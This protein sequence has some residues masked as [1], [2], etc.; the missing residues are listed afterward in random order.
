M[1]ED[2]DDFIMMEGARMGVMQ[3]FY[4]RMCQDMYVRY[5]ELESTFNALDTAAITA[6]S[7]H[8]D[9]YEADLR[10]TR[11]RDQLAAEAIKLIVIACMCLEAAIYDYAAW[12]LPPSVVDDQVERLDLY[13]KWRQ[14][15]G[16]VAQRE[17][18]A[19]GAAMG[20][21]KR[22]IGLRNRLVHS[23]SQ[24]MP[25]AE[26]LPA[27]IQKLNRKTGEIIAGGHTAM[28]AIILLS[29]EMDRQLGGRTFNP[30]PDF[31]G[32]RRIF[33]QTEFPAALKPLLDACRRIDGKSLAR[34]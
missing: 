8:P 26:G 17:L 13:A 7:D 11:A 15:P 5:V 29:L 10:E 18:A 22:L 31:A 12:H 28:R 3:V 20:A 2:P 21:L 6:N 33:P 30:L 24:D 14:V 19:G 32:T 9:F 34:T 16:L 27:A 4:Y 25:G 1:A 23:K